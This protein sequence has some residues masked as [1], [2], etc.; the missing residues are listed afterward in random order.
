MVDSVLEN[1]LDIFLLVFYKHFVNNK[2]SLDIALFNKRLP[3]K[4]N[5]YEATKNILAETTKFLERVGTS[6]L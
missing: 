2:N 4:S 6:Y 3:L 5:G 1:S